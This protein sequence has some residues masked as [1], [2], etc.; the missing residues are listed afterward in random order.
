MILSAPSDAAVEPGYSYGILVLPV[1]GVTGRLFGHKRDAPGLVVTWVDPDGP[2]AGTLQVGDRIIE[3]DGTPVGERR[4]GKPPAL[5]AKR[6]AKLLRN[7]EE[8]EVSVAGERWPMKVTFVPIPV[9]VPNAFAVEGTVAVTT[10]LLDLLDSDDEVAVVVGHEL[11]HIILHHVE[12][13]VTPGSVLKGVVGVGVL[14]PAEIVLPGTG[15]APR[16]SDPGSGEPLQP[17]SGARRRSLGRAPRPRRRLRP[18]GGDQAHRPSW[19]R[20]LRSGPVA[21][22]QT[23]TP[24]TR[25]DARSC[26]RRSSACD[27]PRRFPP[28]TLLLRGIRG[29][30]CLF[31]FPIR[32]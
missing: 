19:R 3:V 30:A 4:R 20:K 31:S 2:S 16:R 6:S 29:V 12:P 32:E 11:G 1:N 13:K 24:P 26:A 10:G 8:R 5:G 9:Q 17:R 15:Q 22:L 27:R 21:V 28:V 23:S 25:N 14:L 18:G 7:G